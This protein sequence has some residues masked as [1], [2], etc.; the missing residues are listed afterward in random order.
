MNL[1]QLND[2]QAKRQKLVKN[3]IEKFVILT[4]YSNVNNS[5]TNFEYNVH[6]IIGNGNYFNMFE[7]I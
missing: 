1:K 3:K 6:A 7:F 5:L 2:T 4:G